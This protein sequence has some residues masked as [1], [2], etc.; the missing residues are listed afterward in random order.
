MT[1]YIVVVDLRNPT[2]PNKVF[3]NAADCA[4]FFLGRR[5]DNYATIVVYDKD[6]DIIQKMATFPRPDYNSIVEH[7]ISLAQD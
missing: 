3:N 4:V 1:P 7:I 6:G 5:L 2:N